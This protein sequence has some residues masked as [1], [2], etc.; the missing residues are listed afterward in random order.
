MKGAV[1]VI[2]PRTYM[3]ALAQREQICANPSCKAQPAALLLASQWVI[4]PVSHTRSP[5]LG[6]HSSNN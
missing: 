2:Q 6:E 3:A 5:W 4:P 1:E